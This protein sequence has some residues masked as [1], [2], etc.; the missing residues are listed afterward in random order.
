MNTQTLFSVGTL[1]ADT[2]GVGIRV[3]AQGKVGPL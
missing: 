3:E 2:K 1:S